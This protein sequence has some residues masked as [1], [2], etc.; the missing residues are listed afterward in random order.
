MFSSKTGVAIPAGLKL[1]LDKVVKSLK[2]RLDN[3]QG[4][5]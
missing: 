4:S 1:A 3:A 5:T 2:P